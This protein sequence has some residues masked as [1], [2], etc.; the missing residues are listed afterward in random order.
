MKKVSPETIYQDGDL[1]LKKE[2]GQYYLI[3]G[4]Q[5]YQLSDHSYELCLYI[6]TEQGFSVTIHNSFTLDE[7]H[8]NNRNL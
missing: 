8:I 2:E 4:E 7:P 5:S 1:L 3:K 6:E